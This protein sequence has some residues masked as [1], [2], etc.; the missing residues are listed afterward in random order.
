[1][2]HGIKT[3]KNFKGVVYSNFLEGGL[4]PLA[5]RL[6]KIGIPYGSF[7]GEQTNTERNQMVQDYNK[8]KLKALLISPAGG[9]GLDL[10][11][12]KFMGVLDPNWN[13]EKTSQAIGRTARFKSHEKLPLEQRNVRVVQY[14]AEP[15]LGFAGRIKKFF[16]PSTHAIGVDEYIHNR[17][18]EK[19]RLNRQ[20]TDV[21]KG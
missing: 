4:N 8:N 17:A 3:D 11:G 5:L 16:K 2:Q 18:M 20:F 21:L 6:K 15:K 19:E 10:K 9:E 14:L 7:T 13:P 12:T 1:L